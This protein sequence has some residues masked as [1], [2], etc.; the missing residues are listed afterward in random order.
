MSDGVSIFAVLDY[1]QVETRGQGT[2]QIR[3]PVHADRTPSARVY[4]EDNTVHCFTCGTSWKPVALVAAAKR[5]SMRDAAS[6]MAVVFDVTEPDPAIQIRGLLAAH[7]PDTSGLR[8]MVQTM[9]RSSR[10]RLTCEEYSRAWLAL[11][12][13]AHAVKART[14]TPAD[15]V[16]LWHRLA[17]WLGSSSHS[18]HSTPG[19]SPDDPSS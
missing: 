6:L 18:D 19:T 9:L 7:R 2:Q 16:H 4:A 15:Q 14:K 8:D 5:I 12:V 17:R 13:M 3:C 10:S 11:D 1:L